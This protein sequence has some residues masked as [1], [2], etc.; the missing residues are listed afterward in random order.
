MKVLNYFVY[1]QIVIAKM[2]SSIALNEKKTLLNEQ[3]R[4]GRTGVDKL[5]EKQRGPLGEG[6]CAQVKLR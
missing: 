6:V 4:I 1:V 3:Q 5:A 2:N